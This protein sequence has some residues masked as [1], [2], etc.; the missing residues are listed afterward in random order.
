MDWTTAILALVA[1][2]AGVASRMPFLRYPIDDDFSIYTYIARFKHLGLRWKTDLFQL[3][4]FLQSLLDALYGSPE[5]GIA[6]MRLAFMGAHA[7]AVLVMF[8]AIL[9]ITANPWAAFLA[10]LL[11]AFYGSYPDYTAGNYS[12]EPFFIPLVLA[13]LILAANGEA[14]LIPA[15]LLFGLAVIL[16]IAT[17]FYVPPLTALAA[18]HYGIAPAGEFLAATAAPALLAGAFGTWDLKALKQIRTRLAI[19]SNLISTKH[20]YF[21]MRQDALRVMTHTAPV[22]LFGLPGL[23]L[24]GRHGLETWLGAF[25]GV[26]FAL[27]VVQRGFSRYHY[28]PPV[29]L[30]SLT[31][32]LTANH[33]LT[34]PDGWAVAGWT[35]FAVALAG[36]LYYL[37][38]FFIE[39]LNVKNLARSEKYDQYIYLPY[40]G[41]ILKRRLRMN[42]ETGKRIFV[43]GTFTQLYHLVGVPSSDAFLHHGMGPWQHPAQE[44]YFDNIIGGLIRHQPVYLIKAFH[45]LN[46]EELQQATGLRYRLVKIALMRFPIYRLTGYEPP[47]VDPLRLPWPEKIEILRKINATA[48]QA[49][50]LKTDCEGKAIPGI[51]KTQLKKGE[52]QASFKECRKL[53]RLNP[54][55]TRGLYLLG[56]LYDWA[57]KPDLSA[58]TLK[59]LL[60]VDPSAPH[61]RMILTKL[62][63]D[64]GALEEA[65][66]WLESDV[67]RFGER[68]ESMF[69]RGRIRQKT[70][71][72]ARAVDYF[73]SICETL[74]EWLDVRSYWA[75]SLIAL[76]KE[77]EALSQYETLFELAEDGWDA[78]W[79]RSRAALGAAKLDAPLRP[80]SETLKEFFD[81]APKNEI[82]AYA[83]ASALEREG[84]ADAAKDLF[85]QF[86]GWFRTAKLL[87]GTWFRL[88]RLTPADNRCPP[89]QECLNIDPL[90]S[91]ALKMMAELQNPP[92]SEPERQAFSVKLC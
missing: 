29:A 51:N 9:H 92:A 88:A 89:L 90:H 67:Q 72:H 82:L 48:F 39:P 37:L 52:I 25:A 36:T 54:Y 19:S 61:A 63:I 76:G 44:P 8:F 56:K 74:P 65:R 73:Q 5:H 42:G 33:L 18:W 22:W 70:G 43:W 31:S 91:G 23:F 34:H 83:Y 57:A 4:N 17:G 71:D 45:D 14:N 50:L 26:T 1:V 46:I 3:G 21:S 15:G 69:Y 12:L 38:P 84:D 58:T 40:L 47:A 49:P 20:T 60:E 27:L 62:C 77:R 11:Y 28:Q 78:D 10:G 13:G 6:R 7:A 32:G 86:T 81:R 59:H 24:A 85:R 35:V 53:C 16:K 68:E 64:R 79:L 87:A 80:E 30:M 55:D 75:E 66:L 2:S 41:R